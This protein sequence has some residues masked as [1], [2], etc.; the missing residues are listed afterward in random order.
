M[1]LLS[2][3]GDTHHWVPSRSSSHTLT[4]KDTTTLRK[5]SPPVLL[6]CVLLFPVASPFKMSSLLYGHL[7]KTIP[8]LRIFITTKFNRNNLW[9]RKVKV[10]TSFDLQPHSSTNPLLV[11]PSC[12]CCSTPWGQDRT[13][14]VTCR[15]YKLLAKDRAVN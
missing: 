5:E 7:I 6:R 9:Q 4:T 15:Q 2:L 13:P 8:L 3:H 10:P 14:G 12:C 1:V 11:P